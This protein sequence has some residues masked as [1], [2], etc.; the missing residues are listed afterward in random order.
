MRIKIVNPKYLNSFANILIPMRFIISIMAIVLLCPCMRSHRESG[1]LTVQ[2]TANIAGNFSGMGKDILFAVPLDSLHDGYH[3]D[4][5]IVSRNSN[6][7]PLNVDITIN[8]IMTNVGD[9]DGNGTDELGVFTDWHSS[10]WCGFYVYTFTDG[11]WK[12][13]ITTI[14]IHRDHYKD[15]LNNGVNVV[16]RSEHKGYLKVHFSDIRNEQICLIDTLI[17]INQ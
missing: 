13:L 2:N 7:K 14:D 1:V 3:Y 15:S 16:E 11:E 10:N 8:P 5:Q 12:Q 6:I 9:L 4:W 17:R